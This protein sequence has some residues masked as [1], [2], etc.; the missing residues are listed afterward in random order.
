M[1]FIAYFL[2]IVIVMWAFYTL[3]GDTSIFLW[4]TFS[5]VIT[6]QLRSIELLKKRTGD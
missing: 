5:L 3:V 2:I 4:I 6:L 1:K